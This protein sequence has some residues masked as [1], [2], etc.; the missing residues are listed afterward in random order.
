M[1]KYTVTY[2]CGHTGVV[3]LFGRTKDREYRLTQLERGDCPDCEED[4]LRKVIAEFSKERELPE[5]TGT[6]RQAAW[7]EKLRM[8]AIKAIEGE[9]ERFSDGD[10]DKESLSKVLQEMYQIPEAKCWIDHRD[11]SN[12]ELCRAIVKRVKSREG[13]PKESPAPEYIAAPQEI[14]HDGITKVKIHGGHVSF[15][16]PK[17]GAFIDVMHS[18][19][20]EWNGQEW[21]KRANEYNGTAENVAA[22][23]G[24]ALLLKGFTVSFPTE[25]IRNMAVN[26]EFEKTR[27]RWVIPYDDKLVCFEWLGRDEHMFSSIKSI[28]GAKYKDKGIN[29]PVEFF[30][31]IEDC[32][33]RFGFF[34]MPAARA[35]LDAARDRIT[36]AV[37][38][39]KTRAENA[40]GEIDSDALLAELTE[41]D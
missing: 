24:N 11:D 15:I 34:I 19:F 25:A 32:A 35:M 23:I 1:A 30:N 28:R 41:E 18:R 21:T 22:D 2:R 13:E 26:A 38:D 16:Y 29:V 5:V 7:A 8:Y 31:D 20:C 6:E 12:H 3:E 14:R 27:T 39:V 37:T 33:E 10:P 4:A 40:P 9:F 36:G 17:C